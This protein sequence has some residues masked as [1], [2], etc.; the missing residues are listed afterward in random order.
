[1]PDYHRVVD[2]IRAFV[3]A[4]DQT[5]T[6]SLDGLA[7]AYAEACV[8]VS[9]RLTRCHRLLQQGLRSEA[10]Q[11]AEIEPRLLD[12]IAT[13]D[14]PERTAWDELVQMYGLPEAPRLQVEVAAFL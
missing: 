5:R 3:Q 12:T 11:L 13:L 7:L 4:T 9:H 2:Q 10:L 14:F 8:E 6:A 1:M